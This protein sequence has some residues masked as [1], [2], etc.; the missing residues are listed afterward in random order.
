[1]AR[2]LLPSPVSAT[3]VVGWDKAIMRPSVAEEFQMR[4]GQRR[5]SYAKQYVNSID[6]EDDSVEDKANTLDR[7]YLQARKEVMAEMFTWDEGRVRKPQEWTD[8]NA[9]GL[10]PFPTKSTTGFGF[11]FTPEDIEAYNN[12]AIDFY[13]D[14]ISSRKDVLKE[15]TVEERTLI[16]GRI[17]EAAIT[18]GKSVIIQEKKDKGMSPTRQEKNLRIFVK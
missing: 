3:S 12:I 7:A 10:L 8:A 14:A 4:V 11:K 6:W 1:M 17:W 9:L 15:L 16:A 2:K 13:L 5:A 18:N